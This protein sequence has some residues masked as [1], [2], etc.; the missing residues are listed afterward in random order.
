MMSIEDRSIDKIV[1]VFAA[2][3]EVPPCFLRR[4][5]L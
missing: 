5:S 3:D 2:N 1:A 4:K